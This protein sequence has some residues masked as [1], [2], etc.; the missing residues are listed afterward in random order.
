LAP[1]VSVIIPVYNNEDFL[2]DCLESALAQSLTD[3]EVLCINDASQD[4]SFE[5]L[6]YYR[7]QDSRVR[8]ID[9][10]ENLGASAARNRGINAAS[11]R[12]VFFLDADDFLPDED[13][14]RDLVAAQAETRMRIVGGSLCTLHMKSGKF[15]TT[16]TEAF[17]GYAFP[18]DSMVFYEDYQF[19]LGFQRFLFDREMLVKADLF[20]PPYRFFDGAVFLARALSHAGVFYAMARIT[21][22]SRTTHELDLWTSERIVDALLGVLGNLQLA[23]DKNYADLYALTLHR[24]NPYMKKRIV[25][26]RWGKHTEDINNTLAVIKGNLRSDLLHKSRYSFAVRGETAVRDLQR[27]AGGR[28]TRVIAFLRSLGPVRRLLKALHRRKMEERGSYERGI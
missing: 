23:S 3:I 7:R 14:L 28:A 12:F 9:N 4:A 11:G 22:V 26:T 21:Y 6:K 18:G 20:F 13:V 1:T 16:Y 10:H 2:A 8:I 19:D 17:E 15:V 25:F 5:I 24:L 27:S